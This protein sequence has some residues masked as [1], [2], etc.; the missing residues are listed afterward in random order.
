VQGTVTAGDDA[1][2]DIP[3]TSATVIGTGITLGW[4]ETDGDGSS[5]PCVQY[6]DPSD[7]PYFTIDWQ[8]SLDGGDT[9]L[10]AGSST[11]PIFVTLALPSLPDG[12]PYYHSLLYAACIWGGAD[13]TD[14]S[15]T[16]ENVWT[17]D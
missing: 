4:T 8:I 16:F 2:F 7:G 14:D 11:H 9:W 13:G 3:P 1:S 15:V 17:M 12:S 5:F 10:D 6:Y